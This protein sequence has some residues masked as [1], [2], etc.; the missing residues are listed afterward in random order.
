ML[1]V[2]LG[3]PALRLGFWER[4]KRAW[5]DGDGVPLAASDPASGRAQTVIERGNRPAAILLHDA[6]LTDDPELLHAA[7]AVALLALENAD[8]ETAWNEAMRELRSSR[9]RISAAGDVERR[10]LERDLHDGAQQRLVAALIK[11]AEVG[12]GV[13]DRA[14]RSALAALEAELEQTLVELR[15]LAHGI[16]P[17]VLGDE[18]L[19]PALRAMDNPGAFKV[20]AEPEVGRYP[21]AIESAVYFCCLEAI[22]NAT[23]HAGP[24][25]DVTIRL[26]QGQE[27]L[28]LDVEDSGPGFDPS[29]TRPGIGLRNMRD[30]LEA[31]DGRLELTSRPG[32]G[33]VVTGTVPLGRF[34]S[35]PQLAPHLPS[36][37]DPAPAHARDLPR[38]SPSPR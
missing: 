22:Q 25:A 33:T 20:T 9:A 15:E 37:R 27:G 21:S 6:Q 5:L 8:L 16:Y 4:R 30:R 2:P 24:A 18:G 11:L 26:S 3:D 28:R 19:V 23:K 14:A 38:S 32:R 10:K 1:R 35:D 36:R 31:V 17:Q 13:E 34:V 7:G 29:T 12:R